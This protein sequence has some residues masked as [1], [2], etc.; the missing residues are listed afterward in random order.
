MYYYLGFVVV[1]GVPYVCLWA[2]ATAPLAGTVS[3][4]P[5][6]KSKAG[7]RNWNFNH[8]DYENY[9][10]VLCPAPLD[11]VQY[12][13]RSRRPTGIAAWACRRVVR[14]GCGAVATYMVNGDRAWSQTRQADT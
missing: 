11:L 2:E 6:S 9:G 14:V 5:V 12:A 13:L 1:L 3:K 4:V 8:I 7:R 10:S